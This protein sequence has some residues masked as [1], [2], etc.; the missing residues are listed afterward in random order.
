MTYKIDDIEGIGPAYAEKLIAAGINTTDDLLDKCCTPA[1]RKAI[2]TAT[3]M[4]EVTILRWTNM[5]DLMRISGIGPQYSE[6]LKGTGVDTIKELRTRNAAN[7]AESM[8][9]VN[10]EKG[11]ARVSPPAATVTKWVEAAKSMSP[12]ITY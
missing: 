8:A 5:A 10:A 11:L 9:S 4:G 12:R 1:G 2:A 7:L 6:L 3:G